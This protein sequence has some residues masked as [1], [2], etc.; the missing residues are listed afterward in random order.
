MTRHHAC[1]IKASAAGLITGSLAFLAVMNICG[2]RLRRSMT[3]AKAF[4][5]IGVLMDAFR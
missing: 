1:L 2:C 3:A 4:R 5:T